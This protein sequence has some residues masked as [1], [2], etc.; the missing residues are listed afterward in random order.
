MRKSSVIKHF[1]SPSKVALALGIGRAAVSKWG[2]RVPP[3][4]AARLEQL[5]KKKLRF[6]PS[7]YADWYKKSA[8]SELRA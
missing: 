3:L 2:E 1:G 4:Q 7:D 8:Q 6:D 5:T